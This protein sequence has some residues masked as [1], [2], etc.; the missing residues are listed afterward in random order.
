MLTHSS[1]A[2]A[3]NLEPVRKRPHACLSAIDCLFDFDHEVCLPFRHFGNAFGP[4]CAILSRRSKVVPG[5]V[6]DDSWFDVDGGVW[7]AGGW[8]LLDN[9]EQPRV[10]P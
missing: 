3:F 6:I 9:A 2:Q 1:R 8:C 5:M 7:V 4:R 10:L